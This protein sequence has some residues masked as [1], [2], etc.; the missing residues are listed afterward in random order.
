MQRR[1][2]LL[3]STAILLYPSSQALAATPDAAIAD[4]SRLLK[5]GNYRQAAAMFY[6]EL[7]SESEAVSRVETWLRAVAQA[8]GGLNSLAVSGSMLNG[9]SV[10][11]KIARQVP[12]SDTRLFFQTAQTVYST[13][14]K[15][16]I[17]VHYIVSAE[18]ATGQWRIREFAIHL[19]PD[20]PNLMGVLGQLPEAI[21][22]TPRR[23]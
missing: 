4:F 23:S 8:V 11:A 14:S 12:L 20:Y 21:S 16:G 15:P 6:P 7:A 5:E 19:P 22:A 2:L 10:M 9:T 3:S 18:E 1:T 13:V 17:A